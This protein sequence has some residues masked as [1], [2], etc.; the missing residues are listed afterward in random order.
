MFRA[1][2]EAKHSGLQTGSSFREKVR[3]EARK[4]V[5]SVVINGNL[6]PPIT[7]AQM[8]NKWGDRKKWWPDY[9]AHYGTSSVKRHT[10]GWEKNS[11]GRESSYS[12]I[13]TGVLASSLDAM[14]DHYNAYPKCRRFRKYCANHVKLF[15]QLLGDKP[16]D[17]RNSLKITDVAREGAPKR[18]RSAKVDVRKQA[19]LN[20][21]EEAGFERLA[22]AINRQNK[23]KMGLAMKRVEKLGIFKDNIEAIGFDIVSNK[24]GIGTARKRRRVSE[25]AGNSDLHDDIDEFEDIEEGNG[26]YDDF[27]VRL[28]VKMSF[29]KGSVSRLP[30]GKFPSSPRIF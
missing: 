8:S 2:V 18:N 12:G 4:A 14:R 7:A 27:L 16:A 23:S 24:I 9:E 10:S 19:I 30:F 17:G 5:D 28:V 1:L 22:M 15:E 20:S 29:S 26:D 6:A 21:T 13:D 25:E 11:S 3:A